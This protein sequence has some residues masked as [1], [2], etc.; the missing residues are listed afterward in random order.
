MAGA[1]LFLAGMNIFSHLRDEV[2]EKIEPLW[3]SN[4]EAEEAFW[5][6]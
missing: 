4:H 3:I 1:L 5:S 6:A 2:K